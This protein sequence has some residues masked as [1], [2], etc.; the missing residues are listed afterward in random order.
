MHK[1]DV[2]K[3]ST[4]LEHNGLYG[5]ILA[6]DVKLERH[7]LEL[8]ESSGIKIFTADIIYHLFD[9]FQGYKEDLKQKAK[10]KHCHVAMFP[11]KLRI[12]PNCIFNSRDPIVIGVTVAGIVKPGQQSCV[13]SKE[14]L[15]LST[16]A[17]LEA[18]N[19]PVD[20][21]R[22]G[23][24]V[25]IKIENTNREAP[26]LY[27]RHF[28]STDLFISH[29]SRESIDALKDHF[30]NE[31]TKTD[32]LL[33]TKSKQF[34]ELFDQILLRPSERQANSRRRSYVCTPSLDK[35]L[36]VNLS[37]LISEHNSSSVIRIITGN[38]PSCE[39]FTVVISM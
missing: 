27:E 37:A 36:L 34:S 5:V 7:A 29:L 24:D 25:C 28:D 31:M 2:M 6:F 39:P 23:T 30:R 38:W 33:V 16:I 13:P 17:S 35:V 12:L 15:I 10:D 18:N 1:K 9:K 21:A 20:F 32:W 3:A 19:R 14:G 11:C 4:M 26:K 22:Q 8:A